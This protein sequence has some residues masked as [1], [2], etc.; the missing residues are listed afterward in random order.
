MSEQSAAR[1]EQSEG[2]CIIS[3]GIETARVLRR[4]KARILQSQRIPRCFSA[5]WWGGV[6]LA[7]VVASDVS[8]TAAANDTRTFNIRAG[9]RQLFLDDVCLAQV[10]NLTRTMHQPIKRGAVIVPDQPWEVSLQ[11]RCTPAWD[12]Q[13]GIYRIWLI[14]STNV[15]G[16]AGTSYAESRDGVHWTKPMLRQREINGSLENNLISVVP[17]DEWPANAIENVVYDRD[18]PDQRRRFKGFYG[19]INRRPMVSAD[20]IH[21]N[22]LDAAE[23]PSQDE[24]NL[25]Y[26]HRNR[27]FIATLKRRGPFGRAHG[28]WTSRD[29]VHWTDSGVLFHAD[30]TDQQLGHENIKARR[31]DSRLQIQGHLWDIR[32]TYKG[33]TAEHKVDV[34]N[35]G[36]FRYE[37]LYIGT[38][39]MF[40]SNDNRWNSDGFHLIQLVCSRD[41]KTF[42]RLGNR[43]TFIG[44]SPMGQG[45]YDLTQLI[46]PSAPLIR[47]DELW[48]YYTGIRYRTAPKDG[49]PNAGAVC[50]AVLRRDGFVSLDAGEREGTVVTQPC[51]L[52]GCQLFVNVDA[53]QGELLVEV[54]DEAGGV[55]ARSQPLSGNLLR[56]PVRWKEGDLTRLTERTVT[57][58]FTLRNGQFYSYWIE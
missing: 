42:H 43:G 56:K 39:A 16:V 13:Q 27:L 30:A 46:S 44:P 50:L 47:E 8:G 1:R 53:P 49:P 4:W 17:G 48:F 34:Y 33:H 55:L 10:E 2:E 52:P 57:F 20:G 45:A 12:P 41:L 35:L 24:S 9:E 40:H 32:D 26:D 7:I 54:L 31:A 22:L 23:L 25:G 28:I 19:A 36:L 51:R 58:R 18:D 5:C 38:P 21:W 15:P 29:F 3:E 11:T 37:D 6:V 14:T